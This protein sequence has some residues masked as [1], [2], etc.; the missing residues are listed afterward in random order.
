MRL[1][2][3]G[4]RN[5]GR[6]DW[7]GNITFAVGLSAVLVAIT[8]GIHPY[9]HHS[10]GWTN[11]TV[12][13]ALI[14]GVLLLAVFAVV[15]TKVAQ[16]MFQ[17][18]LLR[19]RAFTAGNA[20]SFATRLA[21]GGLQFMLIIWLQGIWLPLH[22]YDYSDTPLWA[23]IF[24]L[25]LTGGFL[26]AGPI[27]GLLSDR[28]GARGFA[29]AGMVVFGA[30]FVGLMLLPADFSYGAFAL[31]IAANG[32]GTGMFSSPNSSAIMSSVPARQRGAASGMRSTFQNSGTSLSIGVF[33][34][35]MIAG[36]AGSLPHTLTGGLQ[37]YGV[38]AACRPPGR[39][40]SAGVVAVRRDPRREPDRVAARAH[41]SPAHPLPG[42]PP[43]PHRPGV[44]PA[45]DRG[46]VPPRPRRGLRRVGGA[47]G[48]RR[49]R[50]A[51][52]RW[53]ASGLARVSRRSPGM[54]RGES[55]AD[56]R[57]PRRSSLVDHLP[58]RCFRSAC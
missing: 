24:L 28:F 31:L 52:A 17:I 5:P 40:A 6:I 32:I 20:A 49:L 22:G 8:E 43:D 54:C 23:G 41:R 53:T 45:P 26:V 51:H 10:M 21:Q 30:S 13:G 35:L 14:G 55:G 2:D 1:R 37:R 34:S 50:L 25:P 16:P 58:D 12:Y 48:R 39:R 38:S 19:I 29:T 7:W 44:L 56:L 57:S 3:N 46:A 42:E 4:E 27:S 15:E 11:P 18:G 33:F 47:R 36:L 9:G